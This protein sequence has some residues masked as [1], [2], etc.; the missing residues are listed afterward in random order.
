MSA[1]LA[2]YIIIFEVDHV[3]ENE[4]QCHKKGFNLWHCSL[5][6]NK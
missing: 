5:E 1:L 2:D 4:L 3:Y 6:M